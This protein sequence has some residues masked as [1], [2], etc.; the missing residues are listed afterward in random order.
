MV[1]IT[2]RAAVAVL[3]VSGITM[4][5]NQQ[6]LRIDEN[7][8]LLAFD[9]LS[10]VVARR[11]NRKPPFFSALT[12]WLSM[13]AGGGTG[14]PANR[15]AAFNI[16]LMMYE[17]GVRSNPQVEKSYKSSARQVFGWPATDN[18]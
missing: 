11:I 2:K 5:M 4:A 8:P 7:M 9:L 17:I 16:K 14:F 13:T 15:F 10:R 12:L 6:A 1:A 18:R 3:N